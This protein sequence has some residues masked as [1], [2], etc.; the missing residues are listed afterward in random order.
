[1]HTMKFAPL[2]LIGGVVIVSRP[3]AVAM[4]VIGRLNRVEMRIASAEHIA[5]NV[6]RLKVVT[7]V[8][9]AS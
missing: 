1:M 3:V 7:V 5:K 4:Q 2:V 9:L 6:R 8:S